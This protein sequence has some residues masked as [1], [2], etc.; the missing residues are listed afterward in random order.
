[1]TG[2]E[3]TGEGGVRFDLELGKQT[4]VEVKYWTS[5]YTFQQGGLDRLII[6]LESYQAPGREIILEM[7]QTATNPLTQAQWQEILLRL[8]AEGISVS[9][10]SQFLPLM[11]FQGRTVY[12]QMTFSRPQP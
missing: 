3:I 11:Q 2:V 10:Q 6:Q 4:I 8:Q 12:C 9:S 7:F 5:K 1:L